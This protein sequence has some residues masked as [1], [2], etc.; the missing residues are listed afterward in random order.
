[1]INFYFCFDLSEPP[2]IGNWFSSYVYESPAIG[3]GKELDGVVC[4]ETE[5]EKVG[6][7]PEAIAGEIE[8]DVGELKNPVC[9]NTSAFGKENKQQNQLINKVVF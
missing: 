8:E 4:R 9:E 2:D 6:L 3:T 5:S 7:I 1:M